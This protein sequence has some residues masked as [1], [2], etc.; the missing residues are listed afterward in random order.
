M[1]SPTTS[2]PRDAHA[3]DEARS[4]KLAALL[5]ELAQSPHAPPRFD[6]RAAET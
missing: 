4:V 3:D 1:P 2:S 5:G 6:D